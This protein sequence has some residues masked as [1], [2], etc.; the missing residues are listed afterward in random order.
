MCCSARSRPSRSGRE[1]AELVAWWSELFV[2]PCA[3]AGDLSLAD[4]MARAMAA[5][6]GSRTSRWLPSGN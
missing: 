4:A 1:L 3:A 5:L 6:I 2:L